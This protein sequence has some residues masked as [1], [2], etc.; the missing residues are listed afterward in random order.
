MPEGTPIGDVT[1]RWS[2]LQRVAEV[3]QR[4]VEQAGDDGQASTGAPCQSHNTQCVQHGS[5]LQAA[6]E[7]EALQG[8]RLGPQLAHLVSHLSAPRGQK[9]SVHVIQRR[10]LL[11]DGMALLG[12][13]WVK[14]RAVSFGKHSELAERTGG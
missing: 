5:P 1:G 10:P 13:T 2:W 4:A 11:H 12:S 3:A 14:S 6:Q 7:Q 8:R 9:C